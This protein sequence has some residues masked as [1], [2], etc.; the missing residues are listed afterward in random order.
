LISGWIG[1]AYPA[2]TTALDGSDIV[3]YS[4]V[5]NTIFAEGL[6]NPLFAVAISRDTSR[7]G[8]G[9]WLIVGGTPDIT[10]SSINVSS[11]YGSLP[12]DTDSSNQLT[13]Y[14]VTVGVEYSEY[15]GANKSQDLTPLQYSIDTGTT[16]S[17]FWEAASINARFSP[18]AKLGADGSY[19]V[20][21]DAIPP[22]VSIVIGG[23]ALAIN[24]ADL[25]I[26]GSGICYCG[27]QPLIPGW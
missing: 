20:S 17:H 13:S 27:I 21:C 12:I 9:G 7:S 1:L 11:S 8:F 2:I 6:A 25:I 10:A 26:E 16:V 14:L 5:M 18:P 23:V 3:Q 22:Q 24:P 15:G 19:T 4:P